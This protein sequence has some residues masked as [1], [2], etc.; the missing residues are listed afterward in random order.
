MHLPS[1]VWLSLENPHELAAIGH[2][3]AASPRT[4]GATI[5]APFKGVVAGDCDLFELDNVVDGDERLHLLLALLHCGRVRG[6]SPY[7]WTSRWDYYKVIGPLGH[8]SVSVARQHRLHV[9]L[10]QRL[11]RTTISFK[12]RLGFHRASGVRRKRTGATRRR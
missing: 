8:D 1:A 2:V 11:D 9:M 12:I 10:V 5:C 3:A 4:R 7:D 6:P